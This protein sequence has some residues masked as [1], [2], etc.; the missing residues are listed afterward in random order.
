[1]ELTR[2]Q[3]LTL[4]SL[5]ECYRSISAQFENK[6]LEVF[7]SKVAFIDLLLRGGLAGKK[8]RALYQNLEDL[9]KK[10]LLLYTNKNLQFTKHGYTHYQRIKRDINPFIELQKLSNEITFTKKV[11]SRIRQE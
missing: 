10:K 7:V 9:E 1:M 8:E 5:G 3:K 4:Y 2:P 6:P 11:Q